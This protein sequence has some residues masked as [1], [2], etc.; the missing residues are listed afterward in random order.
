MAKKKKLKS[1]NTQNVS[2]NISNKNN[3]KSQEST[4]LFQILPFMK[5]PHELYEFCKETAE[6]ET[7]QKSFA[8]IITGMALIASLVLRI[9]GVKPQE[10][11]G[12]NSINYYIKM[13]L[14]NN[15]CA[16]YFAATLA[17]FDTMKLFSDAGELDEFLKNSLISAP[18]GKLVQNVNKFPEL[19]DTHRGGLMKSIIGRIT[20][21]PVYSM[22]EFGVR[23]GN[24]TLKDIIAS[25]NFKLTD[26]ELTPE[27]L[28]Y[29]VASFLNP[30]Q[31]EIITFYDDKQL[32]T[33]GNLTPLEKEIIQ[34]TKDTK[35][36]FTI[37]RATSP[38]EQ[39]SSYPDPNEEGISALERRIRLKKAPQKG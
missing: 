39:D 4:K 20:T 3:I 11:F 30:N 13:L 2:V 14:V 5:K 27:Q 10:F 25:C 16:R 15:A 8:V 18:K 38:I 37:H 34:L 24:V 7:I 17:A 36:A 31:L 1:N 35:V 28:A 22:N 6:P 33:E 12:I 32:G 26:F 29:E 9:K 21:A 23:L 19:V